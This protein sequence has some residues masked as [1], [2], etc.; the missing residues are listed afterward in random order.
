MRRILCYNNSMAYLKEFSG[1]ILLEITSEGYVRKFAGP[2]EYKIENLQV[3][4]YS[5]RVIY[6]ID[7]D[8]IKDFYG[9]IV[10]IYQNGY[11]KHFAGSYEYKVDMNYIKK[12]SGEIVYRIDGILSRPQLMGL[13][14]ILFA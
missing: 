7:G 5:G 9:R 3:K 8:Y 2:Y 13:L 11:I 4:E 6:K 14:A 10:L 12:W 1:R